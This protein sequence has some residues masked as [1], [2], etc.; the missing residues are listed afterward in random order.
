MRSGW[1]RELNMWKQL[2]IPC[3][4]SAVSGGRRMPSAA[5]AL[6]PAATAKR[7]WQAE[8]SASEARASSSPTAE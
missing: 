5:A 2:L 8:G 3:C 6:E 4:T 7:E 1:L